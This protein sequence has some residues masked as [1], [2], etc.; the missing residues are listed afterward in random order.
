MTPPRSAIAARRCRDRARNAGFARSRR[1]GCRI[2]LGEDFLRDS[3]TRIRDR[4][5]SV[6]REMDHRLDDLLARDA[7]VHRR[8][9]MAFQLALGTQHGQR[10]QCDKLALVGRKMRSVPYL[11]E[12]MFERDPDEVFVLSRQRIAAEHFAKP[13]QSFFV[14]IVVAILVA[15]RNPCPESMEG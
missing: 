9:E 6:V 4:P 12:Q 14:A 13:G 15:Q 3:Q 8:A 11:A 2:D 1:A 7:D 5:A 10:G